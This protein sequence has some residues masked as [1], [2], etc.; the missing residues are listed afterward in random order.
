M[1]DQ[2]VGILPS[3]NSLRQCVGSI[4]DRNYKCYFWRLFVE[5]EPKE[6]TIVFDINI[7]INK[8]NPFTI[9][10]RRHRHAASPCTRYS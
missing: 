1:L 9:H 10:T 6:N 5:E 8:G 2:L 7:L 4:P 3:P